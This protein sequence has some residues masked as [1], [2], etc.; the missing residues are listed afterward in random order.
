[1]DRLTRKEL[2]TDR[3]QVETRHV[4]DYLSEHRQEAIRYGIAAAVVLVVVL[5]IYL[6]SRYQKNASY[7]VLEAAL[8]V[9]Q[10]PVGST[11]PGGY[12]TRAERDKA[13]AKA[14]TGLLGRYASGDEATVA[15]YYL[16]AM[17]A[18]DGRYADAEK[19]L[20]AAADAGPSAYASLAKIALAEVYAGQ[21]KVA[22]AEKLLRSLMDKP[23]LF[24]SK[25]Q[26]AIELA[27]ILGPTKPAEARKLLEPLRTDKR[28]AVSRNALTLWAALPS[29]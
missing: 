26:A 21:G 29:K 17:A 12:P 14:F 16:G 19:Y 20:R 25:E 11:E 22:E 18:Y 28:S 24:V 9:Y 5:G 1:M 27:R 4:F 7:Q 13:A 6:Y 8:R 15:R 10:A 23:T 2:K 3:F